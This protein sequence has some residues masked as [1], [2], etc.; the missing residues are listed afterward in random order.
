MFEKEI[1][2]SRVLIVDDERANVML[3]EQM[4][5][6]EGFT[7]VRSTMDP[8]EIKDIYAEFWPDLV[9]LDL[10]MPKMD[11][12]QVMEQLKGIE[13]RG[14]LPVMV[15]T[16]MKSE[17]YCIDAL[18]T[19]ARDFLTKPF[20]PTEVM[21]RIHNM[22]EMHLLHQHIRKI[23]HNLETKNNELTEL[24]KHVETAS[25][26]KSNFLANMS[27]E[28]RTP[29]NAILGYTQILLRDKSLKEDHGSTLKIVLNSGNHLLELINDILDISK[30]EAGRMESHPDDFDLTL[31]VKDLSAMFKIRCE[32]KTLGWKSE[33]M[34]DSS[35]PVFGDEGKLRQVLINLLGNAVKFTTEGEVSF[36]VSRD[37]KDRYLFEVKDSGSGIPLESQESIFEPFRQDQEGLKKGGTGLGLAISKK[38]LDFMGGKLALESEPGKGSRFYFSLNLPPA[39]GEL[40][41]R[42]QRLGVVSRLAPGCK[43]KALVVEDNPLN[44]DVLTKLL[45][46]TGVEVEEAENGKEGMDKLDAFNPDIVFLDMRMPVMDGPQTILAIQKKYGKDRFKIVAITASVLQH[47]RQ[48]FLNRGCHGF[49]GKPFRVDVL[50]A[51]MAELLDV[52]YEYEEEPQK[53][54]AQEKN[55][56][57]SKLKIPGDLLGRLKKA[58]QFGQISELRK[59][60]GEM[61]EQNPD[62]SDLADYLKGFADKFQL[63]EITKS[64][65]QIK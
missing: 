12:F 3:L 17:Q 52:K 40:Q 62:L 44:R 53:E 56:D 36:Q 2:K 11:G 35:L 20:N 18:K 14:Y 61:K 23:N 8:L 50:F 59:A 30:I 25:K 60:I 57:F 41:T 55:L 6:E 22:L 21:F 63:N 34:G 5:E 26:A 29:L 58:A 49:I 28:I 45:R 47:E 39:H 15:L 38:Q 9:L 27:H 48:N 54:A 4:L 43:V 7:N 65:D 37:G 46:D 24:N 10:K 31:L 42:T 32:Q 51:T 19:G 33:G 64:L 16:A 1:L 13:K